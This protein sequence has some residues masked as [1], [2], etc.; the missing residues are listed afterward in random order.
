[1]MDEFELDDLDELGDHICDQSRARRAGR[2]RQAAEGHAGRTR[3]TIDGYDG[4]ITLRATTT[5]S[6]ERHPRRLRRHRAR[7]ARRGIN[8]PLA[9]TTAYTV[10]G[11]GCVVA[12]ASP[13]TPARCRRCTV[14]APEG[15]HPQ[16]PQAGRRAASAT[17]S[18]RCCPTWCSAAS[19]RRSRIA[20]RRRAPRACGTSSCAAAVKGGGGGNYGFTMAITSN[21]GTGARPHADGLSAT[22]YPS[23]RQGHAGRDRRG[24][25]AADLLEEGAAAGLG[26]RRAHPRRA[27]PDHRD[28]ERHRRAVRAAGRLRPHRLPPARPRRRRG[29]RA[30]RGRHQGRPRDEGQGHAGGARGERLVV[31]TPGGG[32]LG[33]PAA[34]DATLA[35]TDIREQRIALPQK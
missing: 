17:S 13:T 1:M 25:H 2:D 24:D 23:G 29:R 32:G 15:S 22:A 21:G 8:V 16:C 9:Y 6:D 5:V 30:G 35:A 10:F 14:S 4:P 20:C 18:A 19:P 33:A 31:M 34:R 3:M 11:L 7:Q 26:R 12:A 28:R 27:R